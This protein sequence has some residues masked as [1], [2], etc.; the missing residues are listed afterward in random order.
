MKDAL[1]AED[2]QVQLVQMSPERIFR[3]A[4]NVTEHEFRASLAASGV[5][6]PEQISFVELG[7]TPL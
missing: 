7:S 4:T 5:S 6:V 2:D 3:A 1:R